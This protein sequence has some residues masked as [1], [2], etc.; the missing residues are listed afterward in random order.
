MLES[1]VV[2]CERDNKRHH[3]LDCFDCTFM[4]R[5]HGD[6]LVIGTRYIAA[7]KHLYRLGAGNPHPQIELIVANHNS[8]R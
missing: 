4:F 7:L 5:C 8:K 6:G 1:E 2:L 3:D